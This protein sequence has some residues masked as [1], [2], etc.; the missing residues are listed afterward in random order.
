MINEYMKQLEEWELA[1]QTEVLGENVAQSHF[2]HQ[3]CHMTAAVGSRWL[4]AYDTA[5]EH[6]IAA[7]I[8]NLGYRFGGDYLVSR[9]DY[10]I[11]ER[12]ALQYC[13]LWGSFSLRFGFY[14]MVKT[15]FSSIA[16]S[17]N[18]IFIYSFIYVW[19]LV[20]KW[21]RCDSLSWCA[22]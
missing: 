2:V 1:E 19:Y 14:V 4:A 7:H 12:T 18:F 10:F 21:T 15:K 22:K 17:R 13:W 9:S 16:K 5:R 11:L 20:P 6:I 8:H 3:K